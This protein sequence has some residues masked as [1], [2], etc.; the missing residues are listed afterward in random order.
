M[1]LVLFAWMPDC[2]TG[3][4]GVPL[5]KRDKILRLQSVEK[6]WEIQIC[7]KNDLSTL[8]S[9]RSSV[10]SRLLPSLGLPVVAPRCRLTFLGLTGLVIFANPNQGEIWTNWNLPASSWHW[11]PLTSSSSY[12]LTTETPNINGGRPKGQFT[13]KSIHKTMSTNRLSTIFLKLMKFSLLRGHHLSH[14]PL[15]FAEFTIHKGAPRPS[16]T[17][18]VHRGTP[19]ATSPHFYYTT[20][21]TR[22]KLCPVGAY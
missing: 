17:G 14:S 6:M 18:K 3:V 13:I 7:W 10:Q 11:T 19:V 9:T 1:W 8:P 22:C 5:W 21:N 15:H 16:P 20:L 2:C 12:Y 4:I